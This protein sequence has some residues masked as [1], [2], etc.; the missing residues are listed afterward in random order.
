MSAATR[1]DEFARW[2]AEV[3]GLKPGDSCQWRPPALADWRPGTVVKN[4]G[5]YYWTVRDEGGGEHRALH[6]ENIRPA[7]GR[8]LWEEGS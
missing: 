4:G 2:I 6:I 7:D 3:E 1:S 8:D 5:A